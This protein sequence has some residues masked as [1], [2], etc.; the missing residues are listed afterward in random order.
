MDP[1]LG[2]S[3]LGS[4][5]PYRWVARNAYRVMASY[6]GKRKRGALGVGAAGLASAIATS[7]RRRHAAPLR[8][9]RRAV[10][11]PS[12][13][14]RRRKMR[15]RRPKR[16][17]PRLRHGRNLQ[18]IQRTVKKFRCECFIT[19][20]NV[21]ISDGNGFEIQGD[22]QKPERP[23]EFEAAQVAG[24]GQKPIGMTDWG[25]AYAK[26]RVLNCKVEF[27]L[28]PHT[29][30]QDKTGG[31]W[32]VRSNAGSNIVQ[33]V[34]TWPGQTVEYGGVSSTSISAGCKQFM[35]DNGEWKAKKVNMATTFSDTRP[36][37]YL[38]INLNPRKVIGSNYDPHAATYTPG[39]T[40]LTTNLQGVA[41]T[42][43]MSYDMKFLANTTANPQG[44]GLA[45]YHYLR[46]R[47]TYTMEFTDPKLQITG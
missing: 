13:Y 43:D 28:E 30:N 26:A 14:G 5:G 15:G 36:V 18:P 1:S 33:A 7:Y 32:G 27:F 31:I 38:S 16:Y 21:S 34:A 37:H 24:T 41:A 6:L 45:P 11:R 10:R 25:N 44:G 3:Y 47:K 29:V 17:W 8:S 42:T 4:G 9:R 46:V 19:P 12:R 40:S 2:G 23:F 20:T 35:L 22:G 39:T